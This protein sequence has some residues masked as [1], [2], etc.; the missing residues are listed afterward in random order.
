MFAV[1]DG[2]GRQQTAC[3]AQHFTVVHGAGNLRYARSQFRHRRIAADFLFLR[4]G[5][6]IL[7][8][9]AG[10][11]AVKVAEMLHFPGVT[12]TIAVGIIRR[13]YRDIDGTLAREFTIRCGKADNI[14][15]RLTDGWLPPEDAGAI[16]AVVKS[17]TRRKAGCTELRHGAVGI[18]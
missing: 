7:V 12:Q 4:I 11:V 6:A 5:T 2:E 3:A 9:I 15:A 16:P 10:S 18:G 14:I 1:G 17:G 13:V 8:I